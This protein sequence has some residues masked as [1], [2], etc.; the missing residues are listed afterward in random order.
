MTENKRQKEHIL[1]NETYSRRDN[2]VFRGIRVTRDDH[3]PCEA[4]VRKIFKAMG[5]QNFDR[6]PFVRCHYLDERKQIIVRFQWFSDREPAGHSYSLHSSS[7]DVHSIALIQIKLQ[8]LSLSLGVHI[9]LYSV[10]T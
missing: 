9:S 7:Q 4:K 6:I 5:L 3:E 2:L 8:L 10:Y 1:K